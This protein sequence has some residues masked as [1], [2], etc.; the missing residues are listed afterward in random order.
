MP[1]KDAFEKKEVVNQSVLQASLAKL[2]A[3]M[4]VLPLKFSSPQGESAERPSVRSAAIEA[5]SKVA[6]MPVMS[7]R[8][9]E[10]APGTTP[11]QPSQAGAYALA[12]SVLEGSLPR[13][14]ILYE[15]N[16]STGVASH[17]PNLPVKSIPEQKAAPE[18]TTKQSSNAELVQKINADRRAKTKQA[19]G[20]KAINKPERIIV[21]SGTVANLREKIRSDSS[22]PGVLR[23][24][25]SLINLQDNPFIRRDTEAVSRASTP[26][27]AGDKDKKACGEST[28]KADGKKASQTLVQSRAQQF[29]S[30]A[31]VT[32]KRS[33]SDPEMST[34][35]TRDRAVS[36]EVGKPKLNVRTSFLSRL[37]GLVGGAAEAQ[38]AASNTEP[39]KT[40]R[41]SVV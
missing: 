9:Q 2:A 37:E 34:S 24:S 8:Q 5:T 3:N 22:L 39:P 13:Q 11:P 10:K 36:E 12:Q 18:T 14:K 6:A 30:S 33:V 25:A 4:A 32:Q 21:K 19:D 41:K 35:P 27:L 1:V 15:K 20:K 38:R 16:N 31:Q 28:G 40:D 17:A 7:A 29:L 23:T 26:E